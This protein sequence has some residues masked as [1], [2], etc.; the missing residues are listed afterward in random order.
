MTIDNKEKPADDE[1]KNVQET[2]AKGDRIDGTCKEKEDR[3]KNFPQFENLERTFVPAW[4][5]TAEA[6]LKFW[7]TDRNMSS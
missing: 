5:W 2:N 1:P 3:H 7:S 4:Y 6:I